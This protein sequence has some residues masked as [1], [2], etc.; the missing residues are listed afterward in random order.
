MQSN[1]SKFQANVCQSNKTNAKLALSVMVCIVRQKGH[2]TLSG[3]NGH[4]H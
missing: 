4:I 2:D 3:E 1:F